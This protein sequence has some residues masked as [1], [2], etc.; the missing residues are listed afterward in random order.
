MNGHPDSHLSHRHYIH[1]NCRLVFGF[2]VIRY[3]KT[4]TSI[5]LAD[6]NG[7]RDDNILRDLKALDVQRVHL[8]EVGHE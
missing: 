2:E 8:A 4:M 1:E 6:V 7:K 5:D 3:S